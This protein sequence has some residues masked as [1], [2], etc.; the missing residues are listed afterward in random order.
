MRKLDVQKYIDKLIKEYPKEH[1]QGF[2]EKEIKHLRYIIDK[3]GYPFDIN[4]YNDEMMGNTCMIIHDE[5]IN[6]DIDVYRALVAGIMK[7]QS[8]PFEWD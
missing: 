7:K 1:K 5:I 2:T 4:F 6:Y 8:G 3:D